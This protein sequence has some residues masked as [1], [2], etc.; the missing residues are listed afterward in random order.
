MDVTA[1][2]AVIV[3]GSRDKNILVWNI[4]EDPDKDALL[5]VPVQRT[6]N[7]SLKRGVSQEEVF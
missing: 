1:R 6:I 4:Q 5:P 2:G 3:T 7:L